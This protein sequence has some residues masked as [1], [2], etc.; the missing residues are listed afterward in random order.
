MKCYGS[1]LF[2]AKTKNVTGIRENLILTN[3]SIHDHSLVSVGYMNSTAMWKRPHSA[4]LLNSS[5]K[6]YT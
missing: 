1:L 6:E 3:C 4:V 5:G 2:N